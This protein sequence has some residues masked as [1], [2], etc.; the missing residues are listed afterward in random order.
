MKFV[1]TLLLAA[2]LLSARSAT[3]NVSCD[4][5]SIS[6]ALKIAAE[7]DIVQIGPGSAVWEHDIVIDRNVSFS[8]RGS[9]T[10]LTTLIGDE[11]SV[12]THP[13]WIKS[14]STNLFEVAHMTVMGAVSDGGGFFTTGPNTPSLTPM[15]GPIRFHHIRMPQVYYRGICMGSGDSFGL[16]DHC[17]FESAQQGSFNG[18]AF[19]GDEYNSWMRPIPYGTTNAV[20][21]EDCYF[22]TRP[23][24]HGNGHFDAYN[25][26]QYVLRHNVF[27]G[28]ANNGT[29]GYDSAV[30]STRTGEIYD[31][32]FTNIVSLTSLLDLRGGGNIIYNNTVYAP[33]VAIQNIVPLL[34][35][36]R[37]CE[38]IV[39]T[40]KNW[41]NIPQVETYSANF[42]EGQSVV[43]INQ[44]AYVFKSSPI[45]SRQVKLGATLALSIE[46]LV[47]CINLDLSGAG[48]KYAAVTTNVATGRNWDVKVVS[49]TSSSITLSNILDGTNDFSWPLSQQHGVV[50]VTKYTNNG[51]TLFP[52][53]FWNNKINGT[54]FGPNIGFSTSDCNGH[55]WTDELLQVGRD[56]FTDTDEATWV[57][58]PENYTALVYPHPL[59]GESPSTPP[60]TPRDFR[61]LGDVRFRG[62][63]ILRQ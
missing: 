30:T 57:G 48:T 38:G 8:I 7:G 62:G 24:W 52:D 46:N 41:G 58:V 16:I 37:A 56:F 60:A 45:S 39:G 32:I 59:T 13:I 33:G 51:V 6:N 43:L 61:I 21:V 28:S 12:S 34:K 44:P 17:Y 29:H 20:Y 9:G 31:N 54:N 19:F 10:N 3:L 63:V 14:N 35:L 40:I 50:G 42:L 49:Y 22:K 36:Y 15:R 27:D 11:Y 53:Y 18:V 26:A 5:A 1:Y 55:N 25:G 2:C 4:F 23:N 47:S